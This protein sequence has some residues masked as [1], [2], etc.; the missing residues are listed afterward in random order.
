MTELNNLNKIS[1]LIY[2]KRYFLPQNTSYNNKWFIFFRLN[3]IMVLP[4][5]SITNSTEDFCM[6]DTVKIRVL[7]TVT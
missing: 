6:K 3:N 2:Y 7:I 1:R 4:D 5:G